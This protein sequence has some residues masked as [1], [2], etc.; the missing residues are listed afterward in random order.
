MAAFLVE[1]FLVAAFFLVGFFLTAFRREPPRGVDLPEPLPILRLRLEASLAFD[2]PFLRV[3]FDLPGWV[4]FSDLV[5][6]LLTMLGMCFVD[7][8]FGTELVV[9]DLGGVGWMEHIEHL[10]YIPG[11]MTEVVF[12]RN[13]IV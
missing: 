2:F 12:C 7:E 3:R 6:S 8:G 13:R 11:S 5:S 4:D 1:R 9:F 10:S